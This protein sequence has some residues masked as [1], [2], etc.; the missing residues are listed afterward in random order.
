MTSEVKIGDDRLE[1]TRYFAHSPQRVFDA[2]TRPE[3]VQQWW[4]CA[5]TRNVT[6][7]IDLRVG[8][9]YCHSMDIEGA[10][11]Y[12]YT[13]TIEEL[14]VP[15]RLVYTMQM[16]QDPDHSVSARVTIEFIEEGPGTLLRMVQ[17]GLPAREMCEM[18]SKGS[19]ESLDKLEAFL[20]ATA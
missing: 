11:R 6:S 9:Q 7:T 18:V 10:G 19:S 1:M 3:Q 12:E 16:G 4:G 13:S 17:D 14:V 15:E 8:G 5:Q 20:E 2:W